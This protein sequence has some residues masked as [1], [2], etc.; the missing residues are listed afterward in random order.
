MDGRNTGA[1]G[2]QTG[3][4]LNST[5]LPGLGVAADRLYWPP[6]LLCSRLAGR[7]GS[8]CPSDLLLKRNAI[9]Q[10]GGFEEKFTGIRSIYEDQAFVTKISLHEPIYVS[11]RCWDKY[12]LHSQ[13]IVAKV[14]AAG[15]LPAARNFYLEWLSSFLSQQ[16][17]D[18]PG[19]LRRIRRSRWACRHPLLARMIRPAR[20]WV[21]ARS[22]QGVASRP[23]MPIT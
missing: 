18:D 9:V 22:R 2:P 4:E 11:S 7:A 15:Q 17:F 3:R 5:G 1:V 19:I 21:E 13:S 12:R 20:Q 14:I 23:L 10:V 8:P 6:E 16:G